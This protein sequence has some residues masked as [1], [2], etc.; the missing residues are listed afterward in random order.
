M[1]HHA[2]SLSPFDDPPL[3]LLSS[4]SELFISKLDLA[5]P[6]KNPVKHAAQRKA[7]FNLAHR[8]AWLALEDLG[9]LK[10]RTGSVVVFVF[11]VRTLEAATK[12]G[13]TEPIHLLY[14]GGA[15]RTASTCT[16]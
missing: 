16:L 12:M 10:H 13:I 1:R 11:I 7:G 3:S 5:D 4:S 8:P 14:I 2:C 9:D 6:E 15:V